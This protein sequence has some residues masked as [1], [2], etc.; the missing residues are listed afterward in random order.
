[1][2]DDLSAVADKIGKMLKLAEKA[3][4]P[5]EAAAATA[6]AQEWLEKYNL[7]MSD[8]KREGE[9][10]T[11]S[12]KRTQEKYRGGFYLYERRVW[13][14]VAELNF[15]LYFCYDEWVDLDKPRVNRRG[16]MQYYKKISRHRVVG[17]VVNVRATEAMAVYLLSAIERILRNRLGND[18]SQLLSRWA[19]SFREGAVHAIVRKIQARR[20]LK[21]EA[22]RERQ[23][24]EAERAAKGH[25]SATAMTVLT[26]IDAETDANN[27]FL[28]G[29]GWS[30]AR[31]AERAEAAAERAQREAE[32]ARLAE[33]DPEEH[34]RLEKERRERARRRARRGGGGRAD[35]EPDW[36]AWTSG[37]EAGRK[38]G[39]D[40]QTEKTERRALR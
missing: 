7:T 37:N 26:Y 2:K 30:A 9:K 35:R 1:M 16:H 4:T 39:L 32:M 31:A 10:G 15:C 40:P 19:V 13:G 3:G 8:V 34:A 28:Y 14:A 20:E 22:E 24:K 27:D 33:E 6:R 29:E 17:R 21:L 36:S 23:L 12:G 25:S 38:I 11:G 5:E 18:N